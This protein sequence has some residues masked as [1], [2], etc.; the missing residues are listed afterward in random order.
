MLLI[1]L[2]LEGLYTG[3]WRGE[4]KVVLASAGFTGAQEGILGTTLDYNL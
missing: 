2:W 1:L 4:V 3:G